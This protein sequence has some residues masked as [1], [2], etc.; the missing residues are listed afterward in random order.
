MKITVNPD[1]SVKKEYGENEINDGSQNENRVTTVSFEVPED[2]SDFTKRIV[3]ITKDGNYFDEIVNDEYVLK[4]NITKY[5][6]LAAFVWLINTT[7]HQD[8][9]SEVFPL[10][11]NYNENFSDSVPSEQEI[12]QIEI[13]FERLEDLIEE[14][15]S[16]GS[17]TREIVEELPTENI[18]PDVIYMV[19]REDS[20]PNNIYDEWMYINNNWEKIG[21]TDI[22]LTDYVKNTD[23]ATNSTGGVIK[24]DGGYALQLSPT[25]AIMGLS[26]TVA[27][28]GNLDN[29]GIICKGT[30]EN[31][32]NARIG[33][34][35]T[36]L[37]EINRGGDL[38]WGQ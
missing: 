26:R 1:R 13:L 35:A 3:F 36:L 28:Y 20:E 30:L 37:D 19:L 27:Q 14:V 11:F 7:T 18:D 12:S 25:G 21:T 2:Y 24:V 4:N 15:E 31:V 16:L 9:R 17:L 38:V 23:Y 5:K 33:D 8:F 22:D 6:K 29:A 34:I 32:L 10:E